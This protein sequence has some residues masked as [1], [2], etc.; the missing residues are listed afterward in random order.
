MGRDPLDKDQPPY[1][2]L[3]QAAVQ[4]FSRLVSGVGRRRESLRC[5][6]EKQKL[7]DGTTV[8]PTHAK[9]LAMFARPVE[10]MSGAATRNNGV[11]H[12][13]AEPGVILLERSKVIVIQPKR[14]DD[15]S[16]TDTDYPL[17]R[18]RRETHP[19]TISVGT[20][21]FTSVTTSSRENSQALH[22]KRPLN[23]QYQFGA[24]SAFFGGVK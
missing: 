7:P 9:Y 10:A 16:D 8:S 22:P 4:K 20:Q 17:D 5:T 18:R 11:P 21:D 2:A 1:M 3:M 19:E 12:P 15:V 24:L 23:L 14:D 6:S 13:G